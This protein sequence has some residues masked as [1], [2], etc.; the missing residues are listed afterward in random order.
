MGKGADGAREDVAG[1][2]LVDHFDHVP[3]EIVEQFH[4][5]DVF[6][7]LASIEAMVFAVVLEADHRSLPTHIQ[8]GDEFAVADPD[9]CTRPRKASLDQDESQPGFLW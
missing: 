6:H 7:V 2:V 1:T 8:V 9:L 5:P 3:T 4:S